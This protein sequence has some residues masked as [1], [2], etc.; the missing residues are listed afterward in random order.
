MRAPDAAAEAAARS[1]PAQTPTQRIGSCAERGAATRVRCVPIKFA[2]SL[3]HGAT[4]AREARWCLTVPDRLKACVSSLRRAK[5]H[6]TA[7]GA[8]PQQMKSTDQGQRN[9]LARTCCAAVKR[10]AGTPIA[11]ASDCP[12]FVSC[13]PLTPRCSDKFCRPTLRHG[14]PAFSARGC[15]R[16]SRRRWQRPA[17][18]RAGSAGFADTFAAIANPRSHIHIGRQPATRHRR[19]RTEKGAVCATFCSSRFAVARPAH[20]TT[21]SVA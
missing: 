4:A 11:P 3:T 7:S 17:P 15:S 16:T 8:S 12:R 18:C 20:E 13:R 2:D 14:A 1:G 21:R 10:A 19:E 6:P 5:E 9:R